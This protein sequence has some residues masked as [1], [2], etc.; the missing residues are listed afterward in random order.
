M[1]PPAMPH[2]TSNPSSRRQQRLAVV[3]L[4]AG[5]GDVVAPTGEAETGEANGDE[6]QVDLVGA[7]LIG[8]ARPGTDSDGSP[9]ELVELV[10]R[11]RRTSTT[12]T[13]SA[14]VRARPRGIRRG[15]PRSRTG[16]GSHAGSPRR[17]R[18]R[19]GAPPSAPTGDLRL[20][21]EVADRSESPWVEPCGPADR[22][23]TSV[24]SWLRDR[25]HIPSP[26]STLA[27]RIHRRPTSSWRRPDTILESGPGSE[28]FV[29]SVRVMA[30][31]TL[32]PGRALPIPRDT[33]A[34]GADRG[35]VRASDP[36]GARRRRAGAATPTA[37]PPVISTTTR[38]APRSSG[39]PE[40]PPQQRSRPSATSSEALTRGPGPNWLL[41][42]FVFVDDE[43]IGRQ[44][45]ASATDFDHLGHVQSGS[46]L[47]NTHRRLGYGT[48]ARACALSIAWQL[49]A[50]PRPHRLA[51]G[52]RSL[53]PSLREARIRRQRDRLVVGSPRRSTRR[54]PTCPCRSS[55]VPRRLAGSG[56]RVGRG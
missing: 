52:Q 50:V 29:G 2:L 55:E 48:H 21:S 9:Y 8:F 56:R 26:W 30:E 42:L 4:I 13:S 45:L 14:S 53:R 35:D 39:S 33:P 12:A 10:C 6:R 31:T 37:S 7:V 51:S 28:R 40:V 47:L 32:R 5:D 34:V 22:C 46:V 20:R 44:D 18:P 16:A 23:A 38:H 24:R 11:R 41:P 27:P 25:R 15:A 3:G 49:G 1:I 43:P 36:S 19:H 54:A 17:R